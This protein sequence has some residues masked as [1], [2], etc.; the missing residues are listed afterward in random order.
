MDKLTIK[1]IDNLQ[2]SI[3]SIH[4]RFEDTIKNKYSW[5]I[6]LDRLDVFTTN[7]KW[8]KEYIDRTDER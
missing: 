5:G 7:Q 4:V 8:E 1:I 2:L 6:T 3:K